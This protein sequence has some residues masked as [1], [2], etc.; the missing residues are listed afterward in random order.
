MGA[1]LDVSGQQPHSLPDEGPAGSPRC[2][3]QC[4]RLGGGEGRG[5]AGRAAGEG[6][7]M[8]QPRSCP[9]PSRAALPSAPNSRFPP[10]GTALPQQRP[11]APLRAAAVPRRHRA[12]PA[13]THRGRVAAAAGPPGGR[14]APR[15]PHRVW[16]HDPRRA[17]RAPCRRGCGSACSAPRPLRGSAHRLR[18]PLFHTPAVPALPSRC[19]RRSSKETARRAQ[20]RHGERAAGKERTNPARHHRLALN[21]AHAAGRGLGGSALQG[22]G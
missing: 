9:G 11:T 6:S 13:P 18:L 12:N 10:A 14:V 16:G 22:R 3:P 20:S 21:G 1:R 19:Y 4:R 5:Q 8:P 15:G 2:F 7:A 17:L